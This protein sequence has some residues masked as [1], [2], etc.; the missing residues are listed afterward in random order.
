MNIDPVLLIGGT[1]ALG[2]KIAEWLRAR[3]PDLPI[4]IAARDQV[5]AREFAHVLGNADAT[6][7]DLDR[8]DL[9][10]EGRRFSMV[11]PAF[12]DH[13][14]VSYRFAQDRSLPYIALSEAAFEIAPLVAMHAHRPDTALA[15]LGHMHGGLPA[16]IALSLARY[17][18]SVD[19]IVLGAVFDPADPLPPG[20]EKDLE[21]I[22]KAGPPPLALVDGHWRWLPPEAMQPIRRGGGK[23]VPAEAAGLTDPLG[24]WAPTG[25]RSVRLDMGSA[26]TAAG[27]DG[28]PGHEVMIEIIGQTLDGNVVTRRWMVTDPDGNV[29]FG[30][31]G[32]VLVAERLLGLDGKPAARPGLYFV[33][34]LLD[35]AWVQA[36]LPKLQL[37][38]AEVAIL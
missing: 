36:E 10:L 31:K 32:V 38:L 24:L 21:R 34:T 2:R 11:I 6:A 18:A 19:A 37:T 23:E 5:R 30:A 29:A 27:R 8:A 16:M 13:G 4:T 20:A 26:P 15:L 9:G 3:H 25:A 28:N 22:M 14:H 35:A 12:K 7:I 33:E 17:Y 1:G